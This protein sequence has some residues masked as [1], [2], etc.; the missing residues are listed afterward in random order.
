[1]VY[2]P[3]FENTIA[4]KVTKMLFSWILVV[5]VARYVMCS[6]HHIRCGEKEYEHQGICCPMCK[7][8][9]R[10]RG[11]CTQSSGTECYPCT[12]KTFHADFNGDDDCKSCRSCG[13][14]TF[15]IVAC[16]SIRDTICDCLEGFHCESIT[17]DGCERCSK[18][19]TCPPGEEV[20]SRG[21]YRKN[22]VCR[23]KQIGN[24]LSEEST[25]ESPKEGTEM[26]VPGQTGDTSGCVS[27]IYVII[28]AV[29]LV[30][31]LGILL[32]LI[33][34]SLTTCFHSAIPWYSKQKTKGKDAV[35]QRPVQE[36][37]HELYLPVSVEEKSMD[38][39][40]TCTKLIYDFTESKMTNCAPREMKDVVLPERQY[41]DFGVAMSTKSSVEKF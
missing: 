11:H 3:N 31:L 19:S 41:P 33:R 26:P 9:H 28:L 24:A 6:S 16:T 21:A 25:T 10:V 5:T 35:I 14:G 34:K 12:D 17:V 39:S 4:K 7:P 15:P 30:I 40:S 38:N 36:Q 29:L 23:R 20:V 27:D 13:E 32:F 1:M 2:L 22:T 37:G 8:G 18:H